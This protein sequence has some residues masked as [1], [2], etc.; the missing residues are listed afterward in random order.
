MP[1]QTLAQQ[2]AARFAA[3][4]YERHRAGIARK[5]VKRLLLDYLGVAL[6]GSQTESGKIARA[7]RDRARRQAAG[8]R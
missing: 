1:S 5:A 7:L 6:A 8:A 3:L 2:L 4:R